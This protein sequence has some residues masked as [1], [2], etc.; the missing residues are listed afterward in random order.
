M[1]VPPP[2][3]N[4][5][6]PVSRPKGRAMQ[7]SCEVIY[8]RA[9]INPE[10]FYPKVPSDERKREI[11]QAAGCSADDVWMEYEATGIVLLYEGKK[12]WGAMFKALWG[13]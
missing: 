5:P 1:M 7:I 4:C 3:L 9:N 13:R 11:A 2:T 10:D 12:P 6:A 8:G